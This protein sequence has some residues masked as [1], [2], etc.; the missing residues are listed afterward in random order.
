VISS[1][2]NT[3]CLLSIVI[4]KHTNTKVPMDEAPAKEAT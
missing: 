1:G 2:S 4:D 3:D